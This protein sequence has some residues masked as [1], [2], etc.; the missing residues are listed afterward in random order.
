MSESLNTSK[1]YIFTEKKIPKE[2]KMLSVQVC[3]NN[4]LLVFLWKSGYN[5]FYTQ[6]WKFGDEAYSCVDKDIVW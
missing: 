2:D 6:F 5:G 4:K 3:E 1:I